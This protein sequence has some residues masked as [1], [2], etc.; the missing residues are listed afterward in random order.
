M[1]SIELIDKGG[2]YVTCIDVH[3]TTYDNI[4]VYVENETV[5]VNKNYTHKGNRFFS[6]KPDYAYKIPKNGDKNDISASI[7]DGNL[8]LIVHKII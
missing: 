4:R 7:K 2:S 8:I 3:D 6:K 1:N 5:C